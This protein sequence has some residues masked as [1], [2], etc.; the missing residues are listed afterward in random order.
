MKASDCFY[1]GYIS[2]TFGYKGGVSA[3]LDVDNPQKYIEME[4]V[5]IQMGNQLVPFFIDTVS[6]RPNG[7][8]IN[9]QFQGVDSEDKALQ[10]VGSELY[11][12]VGHLPPLS[13]NNFYFHEIIGYKAIDKVAGPVGTVIQVLDLPGNPLLQIQHGS[14]EVLVPLRDEFIE[15]LDRDNQVIY[16]SA[17]EGLIELY[18]SSDL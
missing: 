12:P 14:K 13:G 18:I 8:E 6:L 17:P 4:S 1:L 16:I 5:F 3:F 11:L 2:K 10:L 7:R 9:I 15:K